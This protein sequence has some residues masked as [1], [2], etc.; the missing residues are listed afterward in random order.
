M[1]VRNDDLKTQ[2]CAIVTGP[3]VALAI[4]LIR[5]LR[6]LF[7][8]DDGAG[9]QLLFEGKETEIVINGVEI[10]AYPSHHLDAMRGLT[11]VAAV[12]MDEASFFDEM[13]TKDAVDISQRY[14]A[15]SNPFL[16]VVSTPDH[17]GDLLPQITEQNENECIY[18]CFFLP[19]TV[20]L[21]GIFS[22]EE[23]KI[24]K[25][26]SS[27]EK[28]YNIKFLGQIGNVFLPEKIDE[29]IALG[30]RMDTYNQI[31]E[32]P[33]LTPQSQFYIGVDSGFG[34][35]AFAIVLVAIL[36]ETIC[37]LETKEIF[38]Q[39]FSYCIN[40]VAN[41]MIK[42]K[43]NSNNTKVI[44]DASSPS[45]VSALKSQMNEA[46]DYL[47][48]LEHRRKM[49]VRDIY[50]GMMVIPIPFNTAN[51]KQILL[52]LKELLDAGLVRLNLEKHAN[53]VLA[54]RTAT[55]TDL[56]LD[57]SHS[58]SNDVLDAMTLACMRLNVSREETQQY[59]IPRHP[60]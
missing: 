54:L 33:E 58:V 9:Y 4:T 46:T 29:A 2:C 12:F 49:K 45:V 7:L 28:E 56:I 59:D 38:R 23:I 8:Q 18:K 31:L 36:D 14:I 37:V 20:G 51:K 24:A 47:A 5:R 26:S 10:R 32:N 13:G 57:K 60:V 15:K 27:F 40:E 39:Q 48:I 22:E 35:S 44:V 50:T 3:N 21:G 34:S 43:L 53:L 42:Y 1:C 17:P 19:Y 11:N 30:R 55:A 41:I 6:E 25:R 16:I 52:N